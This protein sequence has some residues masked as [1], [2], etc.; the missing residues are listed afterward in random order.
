MFL[1]P[2]EGDAGLYNPREPGIVL[3]IVSTWLV[4]GSGR[5]LATLPFK[6][7]ACFP[8]LPQDRSTD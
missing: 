2:T 3:T 6:A 5:L 7:K 1:L 4:K 8:R